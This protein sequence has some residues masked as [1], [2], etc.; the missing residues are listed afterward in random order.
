VQG[1]GVTVPPSSPEAWLA[2]AAAALGRGDAST[3]GRLARVVLVE[4]GHSGQASHLLGLGAFGMGR[5]ADAVRHM[6]RGLSQGR[7]ADR[8]ADVA[9]P[10]FDL[11]ETAQ[12]IDLLVEATRLE[13]LHRM[14]HLM[15]A[16]FLRLLGRETGATDDR[17]AAAVSPE[18]PLAWTALLEA[19]RTPSDMLAAARRAAALSA[20]DPVVQANLAAA[21]AAAGKP[22][23]AERPLRRA[24]AL[25]PAGG[26]WWTRFALLRS[27]RKDAEPAATMADC[28]RSLATNPGAD[29]EI[30][31]ALAV[32]L[33]GAG[34][35]Q[36]AIQC[37][38]RSVA[39]APSIVATLGNFATLFL[40]LERRPEAAIL[41]GR[42]L[43]VEP[44][45]AAMLA[46]RVTV[47][48]ASG[49]LRAAVRDGRRSLAVDPASSIGLSN[50]AGVHLVQARHRLASRFYRRALVVDEDFSDARSNLLFAM[51]FDEHIPA[52]TLHRAHLVFDERHARKLRFPSKGHANDRNPERP[53]VVGYLSPDFRQHPGG[54]FLL[55]PIE[56][57]DRARFKVVCYSLHPTE[58]AVTARF[59]AS[60]DA[61]RSCHGESDEA[62]VAR[63]RAD[64][65]DILFEC[66]GHMAGNRLLA[67]ARKPAPVIVSFPLYPATTGLSAVDYRLGDPYFTPPSTDR[68]HA[69]QILRLPDAHVCY[70]PGPW[71]VHPP[72]FPPGERR[73]YV[74]LGCFN[75]FAKVGDETVSLW[76]EI[77]A[78]LPTAR[79]SLKWNGLGDGDPDWAY[80]RF[81][82]RGIE[83]FRIGL[84]GFS[85]EP[86]SPYNEI[87]VALDPLHANGGTT[88]C[89]AL[90][91]GVP[92][93][94]L[95]GE[96]P[97]SR[98]GLCHLTNVG[99]PELIAK[100]RGDYADIVVALATRPALLREIRTGLRERFARS[101]LMDG[102]RYAANLERALREIWRRWCAEQA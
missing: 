41:L 47:L 38:R 68:L 83:R 90:W 6:R 36:A 74:T 48:R 14:A 30:L 62:I 33:Y 92:V 97:F 27:Q 37:F 24:L 98:V 39:V 40:R 16:R 71:P 35:V 58:D 52:E 17:I 76:A 10:L 4:A 44:G 45:N 28:R 49:R 93:V 79:L 13:P 69:E 65:I 5:S 89:D 9:L 46:I 54:H 57:R 51:C 64:G 20:S 53:L 42:A 102:A 94:S 8:L 22:L 67:V 50:L 86:Y 72:A 55:P 12:A 73:G 85:P 29:A 60:A 75:N 26:V 11:G 2:A 70:A 82:D 1:R 15:R 63:I 25:D 21:L 84:H 91:M 78:R 99:L 23:R 18:H 88:T 61:W 34:G 19:A 87:D 66:T 3:A 81:A 7:T 59:R 31:G 80:A 77:L 100:D 101:P 32:G 95:P 96:T 43:D 56:H